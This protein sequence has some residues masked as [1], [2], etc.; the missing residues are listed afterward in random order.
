MELDALLDRLRRMEPDLRRSGLDS[1]HLFGSR[2]RGD[3]R[4]DSDVDLLFE[5]DDSGFGYLD[6]FTIQDRLSDIL[7]HSV[8]LVENRALHARVRPFVE[9][10]LVRVF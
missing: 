9:P 7:G 4:P 10:D 8:Q 2:A 6:Q 3:H 1:L 5:A